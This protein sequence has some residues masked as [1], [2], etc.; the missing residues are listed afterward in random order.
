MKKTRT[1]SKPDRRAFLKVAAL[2]AA[3]SM[4]PGSRVFSRPPLSEGKRGRVYLHR[5]GMRFKAIGLQGLAILVWPFG[6]DS[7]AAMFGAVLPSG[8]RRRL[9]V[10]WNRVFGK[11]AFAIKSH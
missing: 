9:N 3:S 1:R 8:L 5:K 11:T 4:L 7:Y 10:T 2:A 6:F